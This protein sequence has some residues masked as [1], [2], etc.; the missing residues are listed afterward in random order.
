MLALLFQAVF[1]NLQQ[2]VFDEQWYPVPKLPAG[3][4][5]AFPACTKPLQM[6]SRALT[7]MR[8]ISVPSS[9]DKAV[10]SKELFSSA[11]LCPVMIWTEEAKLR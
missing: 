9:W 7:P 11:F 1:L 4:S 5:A 8:N 10:K 3:V 6:L 2:Y